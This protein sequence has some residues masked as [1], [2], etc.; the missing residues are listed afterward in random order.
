MNNP[1]ESTQSSARSK[2][3]YNWVILFMHNIE[4]EY[5]FSVFHLNDLEDSEFPF[6]LIDG[7][8]DDNARK[9]P[10]VLFSGQN[11]CLFA[12]IEKGLF[13]IVSI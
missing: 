8:L 1:P 3:V 6:H 7:P 9:Q 12:K 2:I 11:Y 10:F 5:P 13:M 4:V